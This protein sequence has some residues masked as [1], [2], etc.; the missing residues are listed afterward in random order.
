MSIVTDKRFDSIESA[1]GDGSWRALIAAFGCAIGGVTRAYN[2]FI[3]VIAFVA[4]VVGGCIWLSSASALPTW[5]RFAMVFVGS[6]LFGYVAGKI[7][8]AVVALVCVLVVTA[9]VGA[10]GYGVWY[11]LS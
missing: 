3:A 7:G 4:C 6:G 8:N 1:H 9:T 5:I 2:P 11:A 10:L